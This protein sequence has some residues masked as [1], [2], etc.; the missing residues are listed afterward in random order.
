MSAVELHH[1]AATHVG[2]VREVNED[3]HLASPPVFAVA[4]GMG[5][6]DGGD[7]ASAIVVEEFSRL[8]ATGYDPARGAEVVAGVL[9]TANA[10]IDQYVAEQQAAGQPDFQ[11]GT[12]AVA[13]LL[14]E[15]EGETRWLLA[16]VGDSRAYRFDAGRLEQVSVDHSLVQELVEAGEISAAEAAEHPARHVVTRALG[17]PDRPEPDFFLLPLA[18]TSRLVLC[19]DGINEMLDDEEIAAVLARAPDPRDAAEGLVA[20]AVA[21]G[22]R[23]N[24]TAVV[25]DVVGWADDPAED[26]DRQR[27]GLEEK[28]GAL[29]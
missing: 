23:D 19:S 16:N 1:G 10:R 28:L 2:R 8:A 4:D 6:H 11:S 3:S 5:G 7:V 25:V 27:V 12:T 21:A 24:A 26:S 17:G 14:V 13:A 15:A 18:G 22:G 29:P 20:E 9:D